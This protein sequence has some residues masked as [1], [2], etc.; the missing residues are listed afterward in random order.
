[1]PDPLTAGLSRNA[2]HPGSQPAQLAVVW[3]PRLHGEPRV[4]DLHRSLSPGRSGS[5]LA[6][7]PERS[8]VAWSPAVVCRGL[9]VLV[10]GG[11]RGSVRV[12]GL[13]VWVPVFG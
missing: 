10:P 12:A 7:G 11:C 4:R 5:C 6:G 2:H 3:A 13:L 8:W 9:P 1:P